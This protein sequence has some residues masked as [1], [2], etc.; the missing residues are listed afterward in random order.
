MLTEIRIENLALIENLKLNLKS[1]LTVFT[2]ETGAGKSIVLNGIGL[3]VGGRGHR[4]LIRTGEKK[5]LVESLFDLRKQ[6]NL[7]LWLRENDLL[8]ENADP[9]LI[10]HR[11]ITEKQSKCRING[12]LQPVNVMKEIG[13]RLVDIHGQHDHQSLL[14]ATSH[15]DFLDNFAG[16]QPLRNEVSVIYQKYTDLKRQLKS[17][18]TKESER[19]RQVDM[20]TF[21]INEIKK[22]YLQTGELEELEALQNKLGNA[23][24]LKELVQGSFHKLYE[25]EG[26]LIEGLQ[27]IVG[28][29]QEASDMDCELSDLADQLTSAVDALQDCARDLGRRTGDYETDPQTLDD[30]IRRIDQIR[31]LQRK[32]G[33]T[34]EDILNFL[35]ECEIELEKLDN[36]SESQEFLEKEIEK[37]CQKLLALVKKLSEKRKN[38]ATDLETKVMQELAEL[39]MEKTQFRVAFTGENQPVESRL[40]SKGIDNVE[41]LISPNVGEELRP[42]AKIASG[43]E[44]SRIMLAIKTILAKVDAVP[45]LIFDEID[46][47]IGGA[48]GSAIGRKLKELAKSRQVFCVTHLAQIAGYADQHYVVE[49]TIQKKRTLTSVREIT[50]DERVRELARMLGGTTSAKAMKH[51]SELLVGNSQ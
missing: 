16:L 40:T 31:A 23:E 10:L 12:L 20:L 50:D 26:S 5:L 32:Y 2:G 46:T 30:T 7:A 37:E 38:F 11:L 29:I 42:L 51:A 21:Q 25:S 9:E 24:Q 28:N 6:P 17:L 44:L 22:A 3:I 45:V 19:L 8:E 47:G 43:G 41:F 1:G 14:D 34:I 35:N 36:V 27:E 4:E 13:R 18:Q 33:A 49:K 15:I 39:S 48:V